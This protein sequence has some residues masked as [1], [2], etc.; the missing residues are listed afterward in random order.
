MRTS[1]RCGW[2]LVLVFLACGDSR[3]GTGAG[4][5][6]SGVGSLGYLSLDDGQVQ[7][8][9]EATRRVLFPATEERF[10]TQ[11]QLS[12]ATLE[13]IRRGISAIG[14]SMASRQFYLN[15][16]CRLVIYSDVHAPADE[17]SGAEVVCQ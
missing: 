10:L 8:V 14:G 1:S 11:A 5:S 7:V 17:V 16:S 13:R 6:R 12:A 2:F 4:E 15:D 9:R 3:P